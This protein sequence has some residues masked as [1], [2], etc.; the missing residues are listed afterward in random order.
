MTDFWLMNLQMQKEDK[1]AGT[2]LL[3]QPPMTGYTRAR[4][5]ADPLPI[6]RP[7]YSGETGNYLPSAS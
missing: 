2:I 3:P 6:P 5:Q 7:V 1:A 4:A